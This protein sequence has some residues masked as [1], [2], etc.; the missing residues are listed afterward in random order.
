VGHRTVTTG[1]L[2]AALSYF[3]GRWPPGPFCGQRSIRTVYYRNKARAH[4]RKGLA[5]GTAGS[6]DGSERRMGV[7][8]GDF[9]T[10]QLFDL[11]HARLRGV[12]RALADDGQGTLARRSV[13]PAEQPTIRTWL[14]P[15]FSIL[16][17]TAGRT[18]VR[19]GHGYPQWTPRLGA[20]YRDQT[21]GRDQRAGS[22]PQYRN[23]CPAIQ[24]PQSARGAP[25]EIC[26]RRHI[27][28][29]VRI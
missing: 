21:A 24:S 26:Q 8:L 17:T 29:V 15:Q 25:S 7:A 23:N 28:V 2:T 20:R 14:A 1:G 12:R 19:D 10:P 16:I 18:F 13:A 27:D 11:P 6:Q 22:L 3:N 5:C 4:S 9:I